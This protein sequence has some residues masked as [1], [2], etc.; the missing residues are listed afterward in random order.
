MSAELKLE[1]QTLRLI[2][3]WNADD[4]AAQWPQLAK[5]QATELDLAKLK[6][7]DSA[8]IAAIITALKPEP[9]NRLIVKHCPDQAKQL[10][11]LYELDALL[12]FEN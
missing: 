2:G 5:C 1:Q 6:R 4:V 11:T 10:L 8:G 3:E 12:Q 7:I 9:S